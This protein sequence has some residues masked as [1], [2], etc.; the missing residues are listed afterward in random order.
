[1]AGFARQ[2][3]F[4]RGRYHKFFQRHTVNLSDKRFQSLKGLIPAG[5]KHMERMAGRVAE[6]V[7]DQLQDL[8]RFPVGLGPL[9]SQIGR[10]GDKLLGRHNNSA[11]S[12]GARP[13]FLPAPI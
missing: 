12:K 1:L 6:T 10:D 4:F 11:L 9:K 13:P 7:N 3:L 2:L 8:F 5:K